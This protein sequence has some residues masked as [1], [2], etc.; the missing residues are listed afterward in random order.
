MDI[1]LS[2]LELEAIFESEDPADE[3]LAKAIT[4]EL[5]PKGKPAFHR[6]DLWRY[7]TGRGKPSAD[8]IALLERLTG[9]RVP[10]NGW[11]DIT[12]AAAA[13]WHAERARRAAEKL[14]DASREARNTPPEAPEAKRLSSR[15]PGADLADAVDDKE[16]TTTRSEPPPPESTPRPLPTVETERRSQRDREPTDPDPRAG[17]VL[18]P[19]PK[20][21]T[22]LDIRVDPPKRQGKG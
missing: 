13:E 22:A 10:A 15:P 20:P 7:R 18:E 6:T 16:E 17:E 19:S 11:E 14:G 3:A 4:E 5:N 8:S 2:S 21:L 9:G 1:S 12:A